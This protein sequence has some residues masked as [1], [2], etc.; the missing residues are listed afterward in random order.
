MLLSAAG[1]GHEDVC[2]QAPALKASKAPSSPLRTLCLS[3][4]WISQCGVALTSFLLWSCLAS[5]EQRQSKLMASLSLS[6][7]DLETVA[8][9]L[10]LR[11]ERCWVQ[12]RG[13]QIGQG[14]LL[15]SQSPAPWARINPGKGFWMQ[16][17]RGLI[18]PLSRER[19]NA[20]PQ[21]LCSLQRWVGNSFLPSLPP[22]PMPFASPLHPGAVVA[23]SPGAP[24]AVGRRAGVALAGDPA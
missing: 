21:G 9:H 17:L 18:Q 23:P 8:S 22:L 7:H 2:K 10:L 4:G 15:P 11:K 13:C 3:A 5:M 12:L 16:R 20:W 24:V 14:T 1:D 19:S 6:L